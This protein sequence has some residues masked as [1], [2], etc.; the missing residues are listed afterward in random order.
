MSD[1]DLTPHFEARYQA[2]GRDRDHLPWARG[3]SEPTLA[4]WLSTAGPPPGPALVVGSG[5]GDDAEELA[6]LGHAVT[7]F[8]SSASAVTWT[9]ERFPESKVDYR[10]ADVLSLPAEWT[11]AFALVVE[12]FTIQSVVPAR[13]NEVIDCIAAT[14]APGGTLLVVALGRPDDQFPSGPPFPVSRRELERFEIAGLREVRFDQI[15]LQFRVE[16]RRPESRP[17]TR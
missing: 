10:V 16:Y 15:G 13:R 1:D 17:P 14:V 5:L 2:A 7:A 6:R 12:V 8:D 9:R 4:E 11:G 3:A